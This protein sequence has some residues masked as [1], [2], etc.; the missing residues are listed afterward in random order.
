[1]LSSES[2]R[3]SASGR[4]QCV[5]C[6]ASLAARMADATAPDETMPLR[7]RSSSS[8]RSFGHGA[9]EGDRFAP[10]ASRQL[11]G[12]A[13]GIVVET[14]MLSVPCRQQGGRPA[15][16]MA[17]GVLL[18]RS[19]IVRGPHASSPVGQLGQDQDDPDGA[20]GVLGQHVRGLGK[21][22][23]DFLEAGGLDAARE[24]RQ[25]HRRSTEGIQRV[26]QGSTGNGIAI[27]DDER[28][29]ALGQQPDDRGQGRVDDAIRDPA[30]DALWERA[31][32]GVGWGVV[33]GHAGSLWRRSLR[34]QTR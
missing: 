12:D 27:G 25:E 34:R 28:D 7:A 30:D 4:R 20:D 16:H 23:L 6:G 19:D 11:G 15:L 31:W 32:G 2:Y 5:R 18:E 8:A 13:P 3:A 26:S 21:A 10:D 22:R 17:L 33:L 29:A 1:M 9:L 14:V 24:C